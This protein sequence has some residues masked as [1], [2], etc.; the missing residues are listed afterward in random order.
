MRKWTQFIKQQ[1]SERVKKE[2]ETAYAQELAASNPSA[3]DGGFKGTF[4]PAQ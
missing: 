3:Q 4:N 1:I 2:V